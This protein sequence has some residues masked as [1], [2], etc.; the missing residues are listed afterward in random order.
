MRLKNKISRR[1]FLKLSGLGL[2][3]LFTPPINFGLPVLESEPH[4]KFERINKIKELTAQNNKLI[5][6]TAPDIAEVAGKVVEIGAETVTAKT[7]HVPNVAIAVLGSAN[8]VSACIPVSEP[9]HE[10]IIIT[11]T[12]WNMM[13]SKSKLTELEKGNVPKAWS[14]LA[15]QPIPLA[16]A[17]A[18]ESESLVYGSLCQPIGCN[19]ADSN[20]M[21]FTYTMDEFVNVLKKLNYTDNEI[22]DFINKGASALEN[23]K[24]LNNE[25]TPI[26]RMDDEIAVFFPEGETIKPI[27]LAQIA[28]F[29]RATI[30]DVLHEVTHII[31][32]PKFTFDLDKAEQL[33]ELFQSVPYVV[34]GRPFEVVS[35]DIQLGPTI[36]ITVKDPSTGLLYTTSVFSQLEEA[37]RAYTDYR[38]LKDNLGENIANTYNRINYLEIAHLYENLLNKIGANNFT[39]WFEAHS[40]LPIDELSAWYQGKALQAGFEDFQK[41]SDGFMLLSMMD[42]LTNS[43]MN[44]KWN[45]DISIEQNKKI[46]INEREKFDRIIERILENPFQ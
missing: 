15:D 8:L 40:T 1:D 26:I 10:R 11:D 38:I 37:R 28:L 9:I 33:A 7:L 20:P 17:I 6:E 24:I 13:D 27:N 36:Y 4:K 25:K 12:E 30:E 14:K 2:A 32:S 31:G 46:I 44:I 42:N 3:G 45:N 29:A 22:Q 23:T 5:Q 41:P 34:G 21:V 39:E 16:Q 19:R 35:I 18:I 43:I